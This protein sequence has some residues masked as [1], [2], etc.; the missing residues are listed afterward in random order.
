MGRF[1]FRL[2]VLPAGASFT[3]HLDQD[4]LLAAAVEF[5][6]EDLFPWPEIQFAVGDRH[7]D[8]SARH[9]AL[10]VRISVVLAGLVVAIGPVM[11]RNLL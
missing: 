10:D 5:T 2:A 1:E 7:Y 11:R 3:N 9:L 4:T 8:F 6:I